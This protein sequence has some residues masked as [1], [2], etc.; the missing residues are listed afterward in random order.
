MQVQFPTPIK[1]FIPWESGRLQSYLGILNNPSPIHRGMN[2]WSQNGPT[3]INPPSH[4]HIFN[5]GP[6][7][8]CREGTQSDL[9]LLSPYSLLA[10]G[11]PCPGTRAR[12]RKLRK[13]GKRQQG[14]HAGEKGSVL[15]TKAGL[16]VGE[17]PC[18]PKRWLRTWPY[19]LTGFEGVKSQR[20]SNAILPLRKNRHF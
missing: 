14:G 20:F 3:C 4:I 1:A 6:S 9:M 5:Y 12:Q 8:G 15:L 16:Q 11:V 18:L 13:K 17:K 19:L 2:Y 7:L 10:V